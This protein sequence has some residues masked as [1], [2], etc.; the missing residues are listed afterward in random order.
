MGDHQIA[1]HELT[2]VAM[3]VMSLGTLT[4]ISTIGWIAVQATASSLSP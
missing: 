1:T 4:V 2:M 3:A